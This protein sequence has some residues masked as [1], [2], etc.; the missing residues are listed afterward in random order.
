MSEKTLAE[1]CK[2]NGQDY[3]K[4]WRLFSEGRLDD[5]Y[6]DED[7]SIWVRCDDKSETKAMAL[8]FKKALEY[9]KNGSSV[10]DF[11]SFVI[12]NFQLRLNGVETLSIKPKPSKIR[13]E[14]ERERRSKEAQDYIKR[15]VKDIAP[16]EDKIAQYKKVKASSKR[17]TDGYMVGLLLDGE[18]KLQGPSDFDEATLTSLL[19][20][21]SAIKV[22][23]LVESPAAH[24]REQKPLD[25]QDLPQLFDANI[26]KTQ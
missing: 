6:K 2:Q 8:F 20:E 7:G 1:W 9:S 14:E 4:Y 22:D 17:T 16:S 24:K 15:T 3:T 25:A 5:V 12:E 23:L 18:I 10:E 19:E 11:A 13:L 26:R 21:S